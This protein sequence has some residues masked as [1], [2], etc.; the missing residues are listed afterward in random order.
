MR[1]SLNL[2]HRKN[3]MIKIIEGN[4]VSIRIDD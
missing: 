3:Q 4:K 1:G 2:V